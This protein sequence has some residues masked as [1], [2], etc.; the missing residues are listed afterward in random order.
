MPYSWLRMIN[1]NIN[2]GYHYWDFFPV[3][4]LEALGNI[5]MWGK[6]SVDN[7]CLLILG[8]A[9]NSQSDSSSWN[10]P[11]NMKINRVRSVVQQLKNANQKVN[12]VVMWLYAL[13]GWILSGS[14]KPRYHLTRH[15]VVILFVGPSSACV[16]DHGCSYITRK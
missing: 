7:R 5:S 4:L 9:N 13:R 11:S 14:Y 3:D 1:Y 12:L 16:E 6:A 8:W 15:Q 2:Q 10:D